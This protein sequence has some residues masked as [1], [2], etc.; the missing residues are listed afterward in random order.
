MFCD[1]TKEVS[2]LNGVERLNV[3]IPSNKQKVRIH[4]EEQ[5]KER[6]I[7]EHPKEDEEEENNNEDK[8]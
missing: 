7:K 1:E 8:D 3:D 4:Y 6:M 2:I 5:I